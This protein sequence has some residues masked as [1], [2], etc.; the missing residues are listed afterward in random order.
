MPELE[1][2]KAYWT[3]DA[4][5]GHGPLYYFGMLERAPGPYLEQRRVEA[6][7]DI[8]SD[9][10]L[11]GIELIDNMPPP[12]C[13]HEWIDIRNKVIQSGE[14]CSKCNLVRAGNGA[15]N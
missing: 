12:P 6:I 3:V 15:T 11:A 8:A 14:M 7:I 1:K 4:A 13:E 2:R 9:G 5:D 10:T